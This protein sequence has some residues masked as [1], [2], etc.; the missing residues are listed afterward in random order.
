MRQPRVIAEIIGGILLGPSVLGRI[1]GFTAAI[2][3]AASMPTLSLAANLGLVLFLFLVGLEVDLRLLVSNWR[4]ALS[5]GAAGMALP[6]GLG[7]AIAYGLYHQFR[8]DAGLVPVG[9]GTYMLFVGVAMAITV[10]LGSSNG[11][12]EMLMLSGFPRAV[13][14]THGAQAAA[15]SG[16]SRRAFGRSRERRGWVDFTRIMRGAR[17]CRVGNYR[18]VRS[19]YLRGVRHLPRLCRPSSVSVDFE[20]LWQHSRWSHSIRGGIDR[21]DDPRLG[22]FHWHHWRSSDLRGVL[23]WVDLPT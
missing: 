23:G 1:P 6:F 11:G 22:L 12:N 21:F 3:P 15:N 14:N 18:V 4:I 5:V 20:A 8:G 17:Q 2:F 7:C 19:T 10:S 9:F 16:W 13:P